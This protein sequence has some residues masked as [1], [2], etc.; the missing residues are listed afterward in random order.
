MLE[1]AEQHGIRID[2]ISFIHTEPVAGL[3]QQLTELAKQEIVAV[4]TSMNAVEAVSNYTAGAHW[5]IFCIGE[6][7][8]NLV[9]KYFDEDAIAGAAPSA[10]GLADVI[11]NA[12]VKEV[13]FFC[14]DQRR[15]ELPD[16]LKASHV[17]IKE[18]IVYR[19][20]PTPKKIEKNYNGIL[21][22]SPSAA[23][24]F[25]EVNTVNPYTILFAIGN[26]TGNTIKKFTDNSVITS[27]NPGK[28]ELARHAITYFKSIRNPI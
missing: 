27:N 19:T 15:A 4:F 12:G 10:S 26:T 11:I 14:G 3:E 23:E 20:I 21:F 2:L 17:S 7:T 5:K 9:R 25:F 8:Q 13:V 24:S 16:K 28:E 6:A 1:E 18:I 22:F